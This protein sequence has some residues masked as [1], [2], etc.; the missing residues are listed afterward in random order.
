MGGDATSRGI[1]FQA[2]VAAYFATYMLANRTP[3]FLDLDQGEKFTSLQ[4]ESPEPVDDILIR[5]SSERRCL[6]NVKTQ[7]YVS[8]R[9]NSPWG[10]IIDQVVR[11]W[12]RHKATYETKATA[13]IPHPPEDRIILLVGTSRSARFEKLLRRLLRAATGAPEL[14][15]IPK[16]FTNQEDQKF[17][18]T[19]LVMIR[20]A[21]LKH[22]E[23][24][25]PDDEIMT[26]LK[27]MRIKRVDPDDIDVDQQHSI[28]ESDV[29]LNHNEARVA[30]D[31]IRLH[32]AELATRCGQSNVEHLR[33]ILTREGLRLQHDNRYA[34]DISRLSAATA[35]EIR[36]MSHRNQLKVPTATGTRT[37]SIN[38][39]IAETVL[40]YSKSCSLLL[41]GPPGSGKSGVIYNVAQKLIDLGHPVAVISADKHL[42][43]TSSQLS[44]DLSL[45]HDL[46]DILYHWNS[47]KSGVVL[48]DALDATREGNS[49][50]VFR[51]LIMEVNENIDH[52]HV[53]ATIRE[54]DLQYGVRYR[55]LFKRDSTT[56]GLQHNQ[57]QTTPDIR[58]GPLSAEELQDVWSA[59]EIL[60]TTYLRANKSFRKL[61]HTLFNIDL[62]ADILHSNPNLRLSITVQTDLLE[63][64]WD[65]RVKDSPTCGLHRQLCVQRLTEAMLSQHRLQIYISTCNVARK[66][67]SALAR[68]GVLDIDD[69]KERVA[70]GHD[71]LF[72]YA[73][74]KLLT[75]QDQITAFMRH[76]TEPPNSALIV[77][78]GLKMAFQSLWERDRPHFWDSCIA[79][80]SSDVRQFCKII[81]TIVAAEM[82]DDVVDFEPIIELV[83]A[84]DQPEYDYALFIIDQCTKS[85]G[86]LREPDRLSRRDAT[87]I[88][89]AIRLAEVTAGKSITMFHMLMQTWIEMI[90]SLDANAQQGI[91]ILSR[92]YLVYNLDTHNNPRGVSLA[93]RGIARTLRYAPVE[94][95]Q[96]MNRL[97]DI[98]RVRQHG[99]DDLQFIVEQLGVF[100]DYGTC[101]SS[102]ICAVYRTLFFIS[103]ASR[104]SLTDLGGDTRFILDRGHNFRGV[105]YT[106]A[107]KY[108]KF[109]RTLP[110]SATKTLIA[111]LDLDH[112]GDESRY[113]PTQEFSVEG[114]GTIYRPDNS[115][116]KHQLFREDRDPPVRHFEE[117]LIELVD[118]VRMEDIDQVLRNSYEH[119]RSAAVWAALLRAGKRRPERL[120]TRLL[121]LARAR[122]VL[123][124]PDC[125]DDAIDLNCALHGR[126]QSGEKQ[127]I[128]SSVLGIDTH[129]KVIVL[130]RLGRDAIVSTELKHEYDALELNGML[131]DDQLSTRSHVRSD[132]MHEE[133]SWPSDHHVD[134]DV[135]GNRDISDLVRRI[136]QVDIRD[137][138][139]EEGSPSILDHWD[140]IVALYDRIKGDDDFPEAL[141]T[142]SWDAVA[143]GV[144]TLVRVVAS[145]DQLVDVEV[146]R[147]MLFAVLD[148][149]RPAV[150]RVDEEAEHEF[151]EFGVR[152]S[153]TPRVVATRA[154]LELICIVANLDQ[155]V[156][157]TV[158][159][160][161]HDE[162]PVVRDE[163]FDSLDRLHQSQP[164][165]ALELSEVGFVR[166]RNPRVLVSLLRSCPPLLHHR[167]ARFSSHIVAL[168]DRITGES[169]QGDIYDYL[170][171]GVVSVVLHLWL[172]HHQG[173]AKE[174][175][176]MWVSDPIRYEDRICAVLST[177]RKSLVQ[178]DLHS[179]T[180]SEVRERREAVRIFEAVTG[181]LVDV[182]ITMQP[183]LEV[184]R[185]GPVVRESS[186]RILDRAMLEMYFASGAYIGT[187]NGADDRLDTSVSNRFL[188]ELGPT[189]FLMA[190]VPCSSVVLRLLETLEYLIPVRPRRVFLVIT[191]A[192][193]QGREARGYESEGLVA[194]L[195]LRIVQRYIADYR[196][197]L[198][199]RDDDDVRGQ[200]V[201]ACDYFVDVGGQDARRFAYEMA[202]ALG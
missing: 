76:T 98:G 6:V 150:D 124:G 46:C 109:F 40:E 7:V 132:L 70:F 20:D 167:D 33:C 127:V 25:I 75:G 110:V 134:R 143:R 199:R 197:M 29:L 83:S 99:R 115:F 23:T 87:W 4:V 155:Q 107:Q 131:R 93:I 71:I 43:P 96:L 86:V 147:Q 34:T 201:D 104:S 1:K 156:F 64:F 90:E 8:D 53:V 31:I 55:N 122:P 78:P 116:L 168:D 170:S 73:V 175:I 130:R 140:R 26:I 66:D 151:S 59:S 191:R 118:Q 82:I 61:L 185:K 165:L 39:P 182:Y 80:A 91:G 153:L 152:G 106:A 188:C 60:H 28:L 42:V 195:F 138:E 38:R 9:S 166:E 120:G 160:L 101:A 92:R 128:E 77:A 180:A 161:A 74:S 193:L 95:L 121:G 113:G 163:V 84:C 162:C 50:L 2:D 112:G 196:E 187:G 68:S 27:M 72:D 57:K 14:E 89:I 36:K 47:E 164:K 21:A 172:D 123:E 176:E 125:R 174:R 97:L 117:G 119:N 49:E 139:S 154:L 65:H 11:Q 181:T 171:D 51:D 13:G 100:I 148:D 56:H 5:T 62:L 136:Q 85:L 17:Y 45:E 202:E 79:V 159:S 24:R 183:D 111:I 37:V 190:C 173:V 137:L 32:C 126:G 141:L 184:I 129:A 48:I 30:L 81:P 146:T 10:S 41:S 52:W 12:I 179:A 103:P 144:H 177:L 88:Q 102:F 178:G 63:A 54:F 200:L 157:D 194:E 69:R 105:K 58:I 19:F 35:N 135:L 108:R 198:L 16:S 67:L 15:L 133:R 149:H 169:G 44:R 192:V 22:R 94:S 114:I 18:G 142:S 186:R 158:L 3:D 145:V 189:L